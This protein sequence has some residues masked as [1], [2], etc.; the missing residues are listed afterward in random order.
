M[1]VS[2]RSN[3]NALS[4][5]L[6]VLSDPEATKSAIS[7]LEKATKTHQKAKAEA[8][9]AA[10]DLA[11]WKAEALSMQQSTTA[12]REALTREQTDFN[13]QK[14]QF[15]DQRRQTMDD[16]A[17]SRAALERDKE[18]HRIKTDAA[19]H[20]LLDREQA[21]TNREAEVAQAQRALDQRAGSLHEAEIS[22]SARSADLDRRLAELRRLAS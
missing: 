22:I 16:L 11:K 10:N 9:T 4:G 3:M 20:A 17:A 21:V 1:P 5:L 6:N 8:E 13:A 7:D 19:D 2:S 12:D 14:Q 15:I 18:D